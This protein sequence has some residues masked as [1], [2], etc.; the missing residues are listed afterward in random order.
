MLKLLLSICMCLMLSTPR[1]AEASYVDAP[2]V[3]NAP[4]NGV[5]FAAPIPCDTAPLQGYGAAA[6][7]KP[8]EFASYPVNYV[9]V[10]QFNYAAPAPTFVKYAA[11]PRVK[12]TAG[13]PVTTTYTTA[14]G[15]AAPQLPNI[16]AP[17]AFGAAP[18]P[19]TF[20]APTTAYGA[21]VAYA[22]SPPFVGSASYAAPTVFSAGHL[23][24]KF[25]APLPVG[26][27]AYAQ[28]IPNAAW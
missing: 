2:H 14:I 20:A 13:L 3:F 10:P 19:A 5:A 21:S 17:L 25:R 9:Q 16:A 23:F 15:F 1:A 8:L 12:A 22:A 24:K 27:Y 7:A 18:A 28:G 26:G 6:F 11:Q 4:P